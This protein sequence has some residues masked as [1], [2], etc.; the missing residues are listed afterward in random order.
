[1]TGGLRFY[2]RPTGWGIILGDDGQLYMIQGRIAGPPLREGER[3]RF[4]PASGPGGLRATSIE[5]LSAVAGR[6]ASGAR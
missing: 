2:D 6:P 5:R 3:F 4:E 1:M